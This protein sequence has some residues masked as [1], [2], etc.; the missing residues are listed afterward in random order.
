MTVRLPLRIS[1][2]CDALLVSFALLPATKKPQN[3]CARPDP[4]ATV[5]AATAAIPRH[6]NIDMPPPG[7]M[8][9]SPSCCCCRRGGAL[10]AMPSSGT[11]ERTSVL[12]TIFPRGAVASPLAAVGAAPPNGL[13]GGPPQ[14]S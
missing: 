11:G 8:V 12:S 14:L 3:A 10:P 2:T 4:A 13:P 5:A 7:L 6:R 1:T 9:T